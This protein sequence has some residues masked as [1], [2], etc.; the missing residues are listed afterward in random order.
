M[1]VGYRVVRLFRVLQYDKWD[2]DIFKGYVREFY[3]IKLE[4]T[5]FPEGIETPE[6]KE[7]FVRETKDM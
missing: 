6:Q 4:A 7:Q 1:R 2:A 3:K 5:G